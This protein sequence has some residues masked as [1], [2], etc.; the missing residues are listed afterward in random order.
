MRAFRSVTTVLL[1]V[2]LAA[3]YA[4]P[5]RA[6]DTR[7]LT[8]T[9]LRGQ[10]DVP[11]AGAEVRIVGEDVRVCADAFGDFS[12]PVPRMGETRLRIT[13]VGFEPQEVIVQSGASSIEVA[14][15]NH[16]FILDAVQVV[17]YAAEFGVP[18]TAGVSVGRLE[19]KDLNAVPTQSLE[20]AMQGKIA[21]AYIQSN[22]GEPG[23]GFQITL[24]GVNTILGSPDPLV[25][26]DG[27]MVSSGAAPAGTNIVTLAG[28]ESVSNRLSDINPADVERIEVLRGPAAAAMYG[29]KAS[30]GVVLVTTKRG[31]V[32]APEEIERAQVL[33]C[34][35]PGN[36]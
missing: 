18:S 3:V 12:I 16:V 13:P 19:S 8:G 26:I 23:G 21:G 9:V 32:R 11:Y 4:V 36:D 24:R 29:S 20:S 5:A 7:A 1:L 15:G 22:S 30:N 28:S 17:G 33:Q 25:I 35:I 2:L 31:H 27:V 10:V 14:L 34:F 6:Q